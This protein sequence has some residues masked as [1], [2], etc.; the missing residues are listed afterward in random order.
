MKFAHFVTLWLP[1][2]PVKYWHRGIKLWVETKT[3][4]CAYTSKAG[5]AIAAS[6]KRSDYSESELRQ[7]ISSDFLSLP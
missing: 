4:N 5:A 2:K 1:G 6:R 3:E 7:Y